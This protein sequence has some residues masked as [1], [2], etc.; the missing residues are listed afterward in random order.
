MGFFKKKLMLVNPA[1][2]TEDGFCGLI[3]TVVES[4]I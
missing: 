1:D 2:G 3:V 4:Y